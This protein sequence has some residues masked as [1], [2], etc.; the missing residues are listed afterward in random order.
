MNIHMMVQ[1]QVTRK[2]PDTKEKSLRCKA[3]SCMP[4]SCATVVTAVQ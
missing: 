2:G 4:C 3:A 1:L